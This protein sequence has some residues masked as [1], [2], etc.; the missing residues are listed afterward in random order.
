MA[1]GSLGY[2]SQAVTTAPRGINQAEARTQ[3]RTTEV[4]EGEA[5]KGDVG[6]RRLAIE[7]KEVREC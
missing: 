7:V 1:S 2:T 6:V 3:K 5:R 4:V